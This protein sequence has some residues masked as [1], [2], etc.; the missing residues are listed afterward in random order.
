MTVPI[1][2]D[3]LLARF[4]VW[5]R[6]VRAEGD[7]PGPEPAS[8]DAGDD[9]VGLYRLVE[10]FTALRHE[11]KLQT[12]STRGLQDQTEA[13][14]PALR[15]AIE[16]FRAIEP[17]EAQA[18]WT[19]GK[20]LAEALADLDE[21]LVRGR[22]EIEKARRRLVDEPAAE[23]AA[24]LDALFARQSWLRRRS[25]RSYHE[26]V[27][28]VVLEQGPEARGPLFD[29]LLEGYGLI[30]SRLRRAMNA[31]QLQ[32]ID[33]IGHP[34]DP[35]QM[36]VVDVVDDPD[37]PPGQ[38][39]EEVRRGYIWRGRVL[40]FAEVRA[41]RSPASASAPDGLLVPPLDGL[42]VPES[43]GTPESDQDPD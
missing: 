27:R 8:L 36:I 30:H 34:V 2:E 33:T 31:E 10:E 11:L 14:L 25:V 21:A 18:A 19:A 15:Q 43:D 42:P 23:I 4:R 5:L 35:D 40:R 41:S 32:R 12:K 28:A 24:A 20:P 6:E 29:A 7:A 38:V 26:Q 9:G 3:A 1:D 17:R 16:Q 22:V 39:V 13:L 37:Q